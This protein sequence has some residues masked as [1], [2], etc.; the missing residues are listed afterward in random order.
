MIAGSFKAYNK[1]KKYKLNKT[2]VCLLNW[3]QVFFT[4]VL[5]DYF[6]KINIIA[7]KI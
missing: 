2:F 6:H 5:L 1:T 3:L 4:I 7:N